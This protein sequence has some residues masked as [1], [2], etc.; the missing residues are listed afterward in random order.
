MKK[1]T[2]LSA[3]L[4]LFAAITL[5]FSSLFAPVAYAGGGRPA[6]VPNPVTIEMQQAR[7]TKY[8]AFHTCLGARFHE[9]AI[10]ADTAA[11]EQAN[12]DAGWAAAN[13]DL[14]GY[15]AVMVTFDAELAR[16]KTAYGC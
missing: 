10:L 11:F 14:A 7:S 12:K 2:I 6:V 1:L 16:L 9:P 5:V 8:N 3:P 4:A 13:R 15:N